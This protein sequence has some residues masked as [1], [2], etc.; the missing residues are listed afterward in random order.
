MNIKRD[1]DPGQYT[2]AES[3][4]AAGEIAD[5]GVDCSRVGVY[6]DTEPDRQNKSCH[7]R[8]ES[9]NDDGSTRS[10]SSILTCSRPRP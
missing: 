9:M 4:A 2:D 1:R 8:L 6:R 3:L 5:T 10:A 7:L